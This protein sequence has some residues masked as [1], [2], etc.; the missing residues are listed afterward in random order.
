MFPS[1]RRKRQSTRSLIA[2]S[3]TTLCLLVIGPATVLAAKPDHVN[4]SGTS[5]DTDFCGTGETVSVSSKGAINFGENKITGHIANTITNPLNG[6]A[7]VESVS[8]TET[9]SSIDDGNGAFTFVTRRT[10]SPESIKLANGA[11][12]FHDVGNIA[13]YYHFDADG[14]LIGTDIVSHGPHPDAD[15]GD[16]NFACNVMVT[17][18]GL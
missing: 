7:V 9:F 17:A 6:A 3:A 18:L 14:N 5:V 8:G 10:G 11:L 15:S 4:V 12:L 2:L 16:P 1:L 13:T